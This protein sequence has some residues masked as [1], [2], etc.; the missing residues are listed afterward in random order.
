MKPERPAPLIARDEAIAIPAGETTYEVLLDQETVDLLADGICPEA[1]A[2]RMHALLEWR[3]S[4]Y[5]VDALN[6]K[7]SA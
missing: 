1:L 5:R 3:R 7:A 2:K 6:R 4:Q